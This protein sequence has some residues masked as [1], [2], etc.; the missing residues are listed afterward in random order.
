MGLLKSPRRC[1]PQHLPHFVSAGRRRQI[2]EQLVAARRVNGSP[3]DALA[4]GHPNQTIE[5]IIALR[6]VRHLTGELSSILGPQLAD[7]GSESSS[8]VYEFRL[9][10]NFPLLPLQQ[11]QYSAHLRP[12]R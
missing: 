4:G 6:K 3:Q 9:A 8:A 12:R 1:D 10:G 11:I 5:A 7:Q 2:F